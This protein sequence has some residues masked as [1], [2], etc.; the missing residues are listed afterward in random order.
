MNVDTRADLWE[1]KFYM[2]LNNR[3]L[4]IMPPGVGTVGARCAKEV[5]P[6][7]STSYQYWSMRRTLSHVF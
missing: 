3:V 2:F 7:P 6:K 5:P 4:L 1:A